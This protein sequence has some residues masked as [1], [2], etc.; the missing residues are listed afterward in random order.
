MSILSH[1]RGLLRAALLF[2]ALPSA[3]FAHGIVGDRFFPAT[4]ATEDPFASDELALPTLSV[5]RHNEDGTNVTETEAEFE[6][7]KTVFKGFAISFGGS[8]VNADEAGGPSVSGFDNLEITPILEIARSDEHEFIASVA[9]SWEIGGSGSKDIAAARSSFTPAFQFGKGFGD[10]P[11]SMAQLRPLAITG[12]VGYEL[13]GYS[14]EPHILNWDFAV[15]YSLR[16]LQTEVHDAGLSEF[17]TRLTPVVEFA[18]SSPLDRDGGGTTG[19][20]NPGLLW[21]GQY[22]QVGVEAIVPV[23]DRTGHNIGVAMQLHFYVDDIYPQSLGRP[24]F[25]ATP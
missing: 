5:F 3:A 10:L 14:G 1:S 12:R 11:E 21:S 8:Y 4:I 15:E 13:P 23:N 19:T 6:W 16:Y 25:G 7:S 2:S 20:I 17:L 22:T 18:F 24:L 9:L